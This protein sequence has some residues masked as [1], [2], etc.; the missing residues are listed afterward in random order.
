MPATGVTPPVPLGLVACKRQRPHFFFELL[1]HCAAQGKPTRII[2]IEL[3]FG[4]SS[5]TDQCREA[6]HETKFGTSLPSA[7]SAAVTAFDV[8]KSFVCLAASPNDG[9]PIARSRP[10]IFLLPGVKRTDFNVT[11]L[12]CSENFTSGLLWLVEKPNM[13]L[14]WHEEQRPITSKPTISGRG[15]A[16]AALNKDNYPK[17]LL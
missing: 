17:N 14:V 8:A 1:F 15:C 6:F 10:L 2:H 7:D 5:P 11:D 16:I 12:G 9:R 3:I 13:M 4:R